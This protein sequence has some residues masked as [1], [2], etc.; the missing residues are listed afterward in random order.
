MK[1]VTFSLPIEAL[2]EATEAF[3][4]GDFNNW[5]VNNAISLVAHEDSSLKA[6]V[7]LEEGKTYEY[8]F[9]LSDGRWEND[10]AAQG[11]V[12]KSDMNIENSV[13]YIPVDEVI[14][15]TTVITEAPIVAE[16]KEAAKKAKTSKAK[17]APKAKKVEEPTKDDLTVIE[18]V[19][20]KIAELLKADGLVSFSDLAK[21]TNKQLKGIL[22]AAGSKFKMHDPSTWAKQAKLASTGKWDKLK[23]LQEELKGGKK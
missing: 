4:L 1:K 16:K 21:A 20:P 18:G 10:W 6:I 5:D 19:G 2:G 7:E 14:V 12:Y 17:A 22:D 13:I 15:E 23:E 3:L 11:Y 8:R 9:L